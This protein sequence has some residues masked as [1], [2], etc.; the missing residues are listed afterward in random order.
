MRN[1]QILLFFLS[2]RFVLHRYS[3]LHKIGVDPFQKY[4][5]NRLIQDYD[6]LFAVRVPDVDDLL[7]FRR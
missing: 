7:G 4:F 2:I 1:K 3:P 5:S 6:V